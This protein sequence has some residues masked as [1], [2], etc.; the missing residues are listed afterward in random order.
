MTQTVSLGDAGIGVL[1]SSC[2]KQKFS[3]SS[4]LVLKCAFSE[5]ANPALSLFS[6]FVKV[7]CVVQLFT[8]NEGNFSKC[9]LLQTLVQLHLV[10][11]HHFAT[12]Y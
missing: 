8:Y 11:V 9:V 7:S 3:D 2:V 12:R 6:Y 10:F 1:V 5:V 4:E